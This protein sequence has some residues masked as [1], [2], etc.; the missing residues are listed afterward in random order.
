MKQNP[1]SFYDFLGYLI[2]G[3]V[4]IC[5]LSFMFVP[6]FW[7]MIGEFSPKLKDSIFAGSS[8]LIAL[9]IV[10]YIVGHLISLLSSSFVEKY[11]TDTYGWPSQYLFINVSTD[12]SKSVKRYFLHLQHGCFIGKINRKDVVRC[13]FK[14]IVSGVVLLPFVAIER[15]MYRLLGVRPTKLPEP[16]NSSLLKRLVQFFEKSKIE[17]PYNIIEEGCLKGDLFRFIY[18]YAQENSENHVP[19]MANYVALYGFSR[20]ICFVFVLLFWASLFQSQIDNW[21]YWYSFSLA[22]ASSI[23]FYG[24]EKFYRRYTLE[25]L[26]ACVSIRDNES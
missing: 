1:F 9:I 3:G 23:F 8:I 21:S 13:V 4:F 15:I 24:F 6:D 11:L 17:V 5:V 20:N 16:L 7:G 18:H 2:P 10:F 26:M 12:L 14:Q 19:K 25:A 22:I